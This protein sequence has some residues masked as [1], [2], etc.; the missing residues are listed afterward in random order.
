LA[1]SAPDDDPTLLANAVTAGSPARTPT[2]AAS[3]A[4]GA[5]IAGRY[6]LVSL[7]GKGGMGDVYRA[8]DLTLDQPV[9]LKFLPV[10]AGDDEARLSRFHN[11]LRVARQ[12]SHKNVCRLYDLGEAG[13]RRFLTMEYVD[14]ED[15]ASLIRRIGR[16][17]H[18]KAVQIA[19]QLCAG[20]AAAHDRGVL[21]RDLKPAN[22]MIDGAGDVRITDFGIATAVSDGASEFVGTPQYMAPEQFSGGSA[23]VRSDIYALGLIVFEVFTGRRAQDAK[24]LEDLRKFHET[25]THTTPSSIVRD[26]DPSVERV[27]LR[28]LE[29]APERRPISALAIA[30]ALP[31]GDPLAAALAAGETPSPDV[32]AAAGE[33]DALGV[34]WGV[35]L[36]SFVV[37][38]MLAFAAASQRT[39]L[40]G[41]TPLD[42]APP[43]LVDRAEQVVASVGYDDAPG[44]TA[45]GFMPFE[46]Y[47]QWL[48]GRQPRSTRWDALSS[49][50]PSGVLFWYRS[51]P[52]ALIPVEDAAVTLTDPPATETGM[53]EVV[54]DPRGRLQRFRSV[55]PQFDESS[56]PTPTPVW[57]TLFDAAGLS[58]SAF[59]DAAPQWTPPDFADARAA[60]TGPHPLLQDVTLRVEAASY[61]GEPVF[62]EVI[63]PWTEPERMQPDRT[64]LADL[65]LI[66]VLFSI[67]AGLLL[68]AA[69]LARHHIRSGRADRRGAWRVTAYM[70]V[71]GMVA[72]LLRADHSLNLEGEVGLL[73]REAANLA[74]LAITAWTVYVAL[75]PYVRRLWPDALLGWSRLLTGHIRDPRVGRDLLTGMAFGVSLAIV[76]V[77]KA[78]IIPA[79]GL[80]APF[81]R[82]GYGDVMLGSGTG[83]LWGA[84]LESAGAVQAALLATLG[85][86][87]L[88]LILRWRWLAIVVTW[89]FLSLTTTYDMSAMPMSLVFPLASGTL[90]TTIAFRFG[91]LTLVVAWFTWGIIEAVPMTLQ[92]SHWRA[93]P[94]NWTL[95][96]LF[97]LTLYGFYASRAGQ[98]LVGRIL[99]D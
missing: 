10:A 5:I 94:S 7:L 73:F 6:R 72:W 59:A 61:R 31:G 87:L 8:D 66:G 93:A 56:S 36:V 71:A 39:S 16:L 60:W 95:A 2:P 90:L 17:P 57:S 58:M 32:L 4:P 75:E 11:E 82:Y 21:H 49:G 9:A 68:A 78:T 24:T 97:G 64:S 86:V 40:T 92:V 76:D 43:V 34:A 84:L 69:V 28:C 45:S 30:A 53:R 70:A 33:S 81:P 62:F 96:V 98:P 20:V 99:E 18:D 89:L 77:G 47:R 15:L 91:L 88:R 63:G 26:L 1:L 67:L 25:G 29:R 54:L 48:R 50:N 23:S 27:I 46:D 55:P 80:S 83:A 19:R 65:I 12:V 3:L 79:L 13:G 51:A 74:L 35:A 85:I 22:V 41:R 44:D 14:G 38:G 42:V 37:V 52:G